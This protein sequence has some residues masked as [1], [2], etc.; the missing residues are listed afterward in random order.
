MI[1]PPGSHEIIFTFKP[2]SYYIGE[3][4]SLASSVLFIILVCG[5]IFYPARK[6]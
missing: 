6:K 3:K 2:T 1:I 5:Y 4:I